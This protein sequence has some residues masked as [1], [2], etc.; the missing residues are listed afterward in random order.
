M[1]KFLTQ[2][3]VTTLL[4]ASIASPAVAQR[5]TRPARPAIVDTA[6]TSLPGDSLSQGGH[7][8]FV[9]L[10][11]KIARKSDDNGLV[12]DGGGSDVSATESATSVKSFKSRKDSI[13]WENA[14]NTADNSKGFRI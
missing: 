3:V 6:I 8:W 4:L 7:N 13:S 5:S 9:S 2:S 12:G 10:L 11:R 14:R 1:P